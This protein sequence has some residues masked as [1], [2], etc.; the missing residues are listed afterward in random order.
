MRQQAGSSNRKR[1]LLERL[2]AL[3]RPLVAYWVFL[4]L[5][6]AAFAL[7]VMAKDPAMDSLITLCILGGTTVAGV[8]AGQF[9]AVLRLR[10][11][12]L[13]ALW[14][15]FWALGIL[16]GVFAAS[17]AG[18]AG[19]LVFVFFL[20]FP[21]FALGGA[22]SLRA[23]RALF[24]GF[25]PLVYAS[26]CAIVVAQKAGRVEDWKAGS[27][28]AIWDGFTISVLG[29]GIL[30]F[31]A[32]LL[33]REGHRLA[34]WRRGPRAPLLGS[35]RETGAVRPRLSCAGWVLVGMLALVLT[36]G[37]ALMAPY[38][39]RTGPGRGGQA[40]SGTGD[41][42]IADQDDGDTPSSGQQGGGSPSTAQ[43]QQPAA[44]SDLQRRWQQ[45][46]GQAIKEAREELRPQVAQGL[47][48]LGTV[49]TVLALFLLCMVVFYRPVRRLLL[50]RHYQR[51][52]IPLSPT[53]RIRNGWRLVELALGD[54]G[55]SPRPNEPAASLLARA[56]P[57]LA[58]L[59]AAQV[60]VHGL[61]QAAE[62]RDRVEYG[63]GLAPD[64]LRQMDRTARWTYHTVWDRLGEW[65][66]VR[67]LYRRI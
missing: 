40:S 52:F 60:E 2:R 67:L 6:F 44:P 38:L 23:G 65:T 47:D 7:V 24:G 34:L 36:L 33:A 59:S 63:L 4:V 1:L 13:F 51:P 27:K 29:V 56:G 22:W 43:G 64:D 10:D 42:V 21:I 41:D 30:L 3:V 46:G 11:W 20:L 48:L 8:L 57:T 28:W 49:L 45:A 66:R 16:A 50:A 61:A 54:A 53:A 25:V 62:I 12:V 15:V 18:A 55:V 26:G 17:L 14:A 9:A 31:L 39:W 58:S 19:I 37:S 32:Y 5:M 35:V